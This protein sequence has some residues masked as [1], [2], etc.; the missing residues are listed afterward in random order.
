MEIL[1]KP[2]ER[3]PGLVLVFGLLCLFMLENN[4]EPAGLLR[5]FLIAWILYRLGSV[6]DVLFGL[7]YGAEPEQLPLGRPRCLWQRIYWKLYKRSYPIRVRWYKLRAQKGFVP[8]FRR[9]E[10]VRRSAS[11]RAKGVIGKEQWEADV[12]PLLN[13]SKLAR[14]FVIPLF[15][16]SILQVVV[17]MAMMVRWAVN[18]IANGNYAPTLDKFWMP[19]RASLEPFFAPFIRDFELANDKLRLFPEFTVGGISVFA[20]IFCLLFL[21][22]CISLRI[23]HMFQLYDLAMKKA[24]P[25]SD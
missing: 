24:G 5:A 23:E 4:S 19:F 14:T 8:C 25:H 2:L 7:L 6:L 1:E 3:I 18:A 17:P 22:T 20:A 16:A 9:L 10:A 12:A 21:Y 11:K 15:V 13:R